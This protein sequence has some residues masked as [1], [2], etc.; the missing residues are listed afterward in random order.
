MPGLARKLLIFAAVD[1]LI[2]QPVQPRNHRQTTEQAIKIGYQTEDDAGHAIQPLLQNR[3][4]DDFAKD[5]LEAHGIIGMITS[6]LFMPL[7]SR[8]LI[9]KRQVC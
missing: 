2:L 1:G 7:Q 3:R 4:A 6:E 9:A 5:A 8:G